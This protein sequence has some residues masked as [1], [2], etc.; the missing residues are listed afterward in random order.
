MSD[1]IPHIGMEF[2]NSHEA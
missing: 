2:R 1:L